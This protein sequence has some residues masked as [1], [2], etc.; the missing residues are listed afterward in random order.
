VADPSLSRFTRAELFAVLKNEKLVKLFEALLTTATT[1]EDLTAVET[2]LNDHITDAGDAH[3]ASAIGAIP[4][5]D[6][7]GNTVAA[8]LVELDAEKKAEDFAPPTVNEAPAGDVSPP[9]ASEPP[10]G[11][12]SPPM[13]FEAVQA[14]MTEVAGLSELVT[15]LAKQ[16]NDIQQGTDL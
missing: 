1:E 5:G 8:Q 11:D 15:A 14:L 13:V 6:L 10:A 2:A 12:V 16:I 4:S 3:Q 7:A 9:A